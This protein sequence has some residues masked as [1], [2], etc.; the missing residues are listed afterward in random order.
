MTSVWT[1]DLPL[2]PSDPLQDGDRYDHVV[3]GAGLTGLT[4]ALLLARSGS[5]VVVV[6]ARTPGAVTTGHTTAKV[7]LLQG[8]KLSQV[9][10]RRG[11]SVARDYVDANREGQQWLLR[12]CEDHGVAAQIRPAVTYASSPS[13]VETVRREHEAASSLGLEVRWHDHLD[14][15]FEVHGAT[16]LPG[17]AQVEAGQ[18]VAALARD[19]REHGGAIVHGQRVVKVRADGDAVVAHV[20]D[21]RRVFGRH[22]VVATGMPFLDRGFH[23]AR[24]DPQRSYVVTFT[25]V[26][27]PE[28]MYLSAGTPSRSVRDVPRPDGTQ[29]MIGGSGH[30]VGRDPSP[31]KHLDELRAWTAERFPGAVETHAWSAQDYSPADHIPYV[32]ELPGSG[33]RIFVATGYDKWGMTQGVAAAR[34][35]SSWILGNDPAWARPMRSSMP[36]LSGAASAALINGKVGLELAKGYVRAELAPLP[37]HAPAEG[38]GVVGRRGVKP[39]AVST[40]DGRT[41]AVSAVCTH[42]GGVLRWNDAE[43]SWDCPLHGSRFDADGTVLEGPATRPLDRTEAPRP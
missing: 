17:Q 30:G 4:T 23:F 27:A 14:V 1:A 38:E 25:G 34:A 24:L 16:L 32:G 21:G 18:M 36:T 12:F 37:A 43:K 20:E 35:V 2:D 29:L 33:G 19:L 28:G 22:L 7:S 9:L 31:A 5:R 41:C 40:V 8:T 15:P 10:S 6:E 11:A 13:Q 39:V 3:V 26:T 42:L